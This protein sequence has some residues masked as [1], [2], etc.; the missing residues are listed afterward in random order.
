M[1]SI[2]IVLE[3][4]TIKFLIGLYAIW[5]TV[6]ICLF[7]DWYH[8]QTVLYPNIKI[9]MSVAEYINLTA[10]LVATLIFV[11]MWVI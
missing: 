3:P 6:T 10:W 1:N 8:E 7:C 2:T 4:N 9:K 11:I 5:S